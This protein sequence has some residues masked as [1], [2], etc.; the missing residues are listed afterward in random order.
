MKIPIFE[1]ILL[2]EV[3]PEK[4]RTIVSDSRI[5]KVPCYLNLSNLNKEATEQM[6]VNLAQIILEHN[7]HPRFP[8]PLYI[9]STISVKSIFPWVRTVKD[10]PEHYFKKVKR[11][12]NKELQLLNKLSLKV[13]KIKNLELYKI[14]NEFRDSTESQRKLYNET[15]ELYFLETLN[16]RLFERSKK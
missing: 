13:D 6:V 16:S 15:K 8:Y 14:I 9:V 10:L 12:S 11:P 3:T 7:I 4:L 2:S 1:E 5:G